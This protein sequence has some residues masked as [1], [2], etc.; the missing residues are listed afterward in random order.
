MEN[1]LLDV[2]EPSIITN[3]LLVITSQTILIR[4]LGKF[5]MINLYMRPGIQ[6]VS[7]AFSRSIKQAAT[8]C[9]AFRAQQM[10]D[11]SLFIA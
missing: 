9:F 7:K 1:S 11:V 4:C 8:G 10:S 3:V 6:T 2:F 5:F